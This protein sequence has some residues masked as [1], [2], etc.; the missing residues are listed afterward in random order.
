MP[1]TSSPRFPPALVIPLGILAV[2]TASILIRYAQAEASSLA[3]AAFRLGLSVIFLSPYVICKHREELR[4]LTGPDLRLALFSGLLLAVHFASWISSLEYTSV[5]SSVVLVTTTPLWVAVMGPLFLGEKVSRQALG[6]MGLA[7]IGGVVVALSDGC[8][9]SLF[10]FSCPSSGGMAGSQALLGDGL[11]LLGA[12]TAAGYMMVGRHL[13][14]K[15]S[16]ASYIF[17]VYLM[18]A[19]CLFLVLLLREGIPTGYSPVI[20]LWLI[21]LALVPQLMGHTILNWALRYLPAA[22][23]SLS[24]L[25]EPIGSTVLAALFLG[26]RPSALKIFGAILILLGIAAASGKTEVGRK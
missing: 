7:L 13:R 11:A 3:I 14:Q 12:L 4:G 8:Q 5:A 9:G 15:L 25:G 22:L 17:L 2:S 24:L 23:V 10:Q 20:Y 18:A 21:L 26:E 6:G 16:L 1:G 19:A